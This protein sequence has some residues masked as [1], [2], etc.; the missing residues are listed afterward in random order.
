MQGFLNKPAELQELDDNNKYLSDERSLC[1]KLLKKSN[2]KNVES[3]RN[4]IDMNR[5]S[6]VCNCKFKSCLLI[7]GGDWMWISQILD[8]TGPR[9]LHFCKDCLAKLSNLEKGKTHTPYPLP[10]YQNFAP[11]KYSFQ[12]R[13][14][15]SM[16]QN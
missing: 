8:L 2:L 4:E 1:T 13:T 14:F 12:Q 7:L 16:E 10:K 15:E 3:E 11:E 6:A 9:G 5:Q